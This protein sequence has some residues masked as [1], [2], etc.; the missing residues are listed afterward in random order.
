MDERG[1]P[2][3]QYPVSISRPNFKPLYA[4]TDAKG[5]YSFFGLAPG[6]YTIQGVPDNQV[7]VTVQVG[8]GG[9]SRAGNLVI[10]HSKS[11]VVPGAQNSWKDTGIQI[12]RGD[13][14][15]FSATGQVAWSKGESAGPE[16]SSSNLKPVAGRPA[17]PVS[18]IGAGGLIAKV[19]SGTAFAVGKKATVVASQAGTLYLW[20]NDN[21]Y[22]DNSGQFT[23]MIEWSA[24]Q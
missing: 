15:L 17:Y 22:G 21:N 24:A 12:S 14:I 7:R 18:G 10:R 19:G 13:R 2:I 16:G 4:I 20:L 8:T 5:E 3:A 23:V 1:K 11:V 6:S 9:M